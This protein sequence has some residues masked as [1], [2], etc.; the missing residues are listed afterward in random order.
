MLRVPL[1]PSA[2]IPPVRA[3]PA[4]SVRTSASRG[5]EQSPRDQWWITTLAV[6]LLLV[7]PIYGRVASN[8]VA[9]LTIQVIGAC[10]GSVGGIAGLV[11]FVGMLAYLFACDRSSRKAL[12]VLIFLLT[13][14]LIQSVLFHGLSKADAYSIRRL[15][16]AGTDE[17]VPE[18][19]REPSCNPGQ[20]PPYPVLL[21]NDLNGIRD[22]DPLP[23][24]ARA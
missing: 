20:Q 12:W 22:N 19:E 17:S 1:A 11:I 7:I 5:C 2:E 9:R 10:L 16:I 21:K 13:A 24:A 23:G 15:G 3:V 14:C 18:S 8:D 4:E 6:F